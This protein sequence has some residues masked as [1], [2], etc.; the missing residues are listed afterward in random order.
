M[1]PI[2]HFY[3]DIQGWFNFEPFYRSMVRRA[4]ENKRSHFVEVGCWK[5]KSAAFMA[6]E[7][8]NSGKDI[9]FDC[10]DTFRGS[11]EKAH[12]SD[13]DVRNGTLLRTFQKNM[14]P[15]AAF[16]HVIWKPSVVAARFYQDGEL[17]LVFIDASHEFLDVRADIKAWLPKLRRG[18]ILAG[19]DYG[20][21][22]V[23]KAVDEQLGDGV[24]IWP[25]KTWEYRKP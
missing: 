12:K 23:K 11:N 13:P 7:I 18:G 19:D 5:G 20:W 21:E 4:P 24:K 17:D 9:W 16:H 25:E 6:V 1:P 22:G 2:K 3:Q 14:E 8:A 15:V 10:V